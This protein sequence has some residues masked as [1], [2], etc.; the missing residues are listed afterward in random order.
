MASITV[1]R[2]EIVTIAL[3][4]ARAYIDKDILYRN[5]NALHGGIYVPIDTGVS[6]NPFYPPSVQERDVITPSGRHLPLVNPAYMTRQIYERTRYSRQDCGF[7]CM[8]VDAADVRKAML[9]E[10][11][12]LSDARTAELRAYFWGGI[13]PYRVKVSV[14]RDLTLNPP[15]QGGA[16]NYLMYPFA[17]M[18]GKTV[19]WLDPATFKY[20][21]I[22]SAK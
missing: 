22:Y 9:T 12:E 10:N 14:G 11:L 5:W 13:D 7:F 19:D 18:G 21:I 20:S 3:N 8:P 1:H 17:Q 2:Q 6:P 16:V 15:Q 4:V